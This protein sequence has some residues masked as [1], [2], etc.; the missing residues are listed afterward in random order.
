MA[1]LSRGKIIVGDSSGNPSALALGSS[2]QV[3]KSDGSDLVFG[4]D[5]GLSTEEVQEMIQKQEAQQRAMMEQQQ[6]QVVAQVDEKQA[7]AE[8][9]RSQARAA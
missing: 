9:K 4:A 6:A 7:N 5:S 2:G 3:L 8:A 1:G